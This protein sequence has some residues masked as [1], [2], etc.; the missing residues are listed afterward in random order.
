[1]LQPILLAAKLALTLA[2]PLCFNK[3][4]LPEVILSA[5]VVDSFNVVSSISVE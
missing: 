3:E 4:N 5:C 1:M 2:A